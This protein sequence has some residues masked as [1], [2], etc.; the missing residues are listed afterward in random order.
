M[1]ADA[2]AFNQ[3]L[4]KWDVSNVTDMEEM[5]ED[6][7]FNQPLNNWN[8][9]NVRYMNFMFMDLEIGGC[10]QTKKRGTQR[11]AWIFGLCADWRNNN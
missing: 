7:P 9:S 4:N 11:D 8:V 10:G 6:A 3:P 2:E 1:F 5:F